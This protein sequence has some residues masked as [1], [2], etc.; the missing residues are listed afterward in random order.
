MSVA[1]STLPPRQR[2]LLTAH[3][4]FYRDGIRATGIDRIISESGVAKVTFYRHFPS[5]NE[6]IEA[7]LAYRHDQWLS[8]FSRSLEQHATRRGDV[9]LALVPCLEEW[10]S[11]PHYRGCAFINTAVE[12]AEML[13]ESLKIARLHKKQMAEVIASYLPTSSEREQR[14]EMLSMLIDGAIVKVQIEQQPQN[15][16]LLL[17]EMLKTLAA[18]WKHQ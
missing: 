16:L 13:P 12:L 3:D 18:T 4:L 14:A 9:M 6:L 10:F 17:S 15:A 5:K 2:I 11:S 1:P 7:F 8:W